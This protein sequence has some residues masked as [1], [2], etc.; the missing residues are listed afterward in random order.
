RRVASGRIWSH[1]VASGRIGSG[2]RVW[3]GLT[4]GGGDGVLLF[5]LI[6][7][8]NRSWWA[9]RQMDSHTPGMKEAILYDYDFPRALVY[10]RAFERS[11]E[12][13]SELQS[14]ENLVCRLLLEKKK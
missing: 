7:R 6:V 3:F 4:S 2:R 10:Q 8:P 1:R 9:T 5:P 13:T 11:E 14:R 12:H